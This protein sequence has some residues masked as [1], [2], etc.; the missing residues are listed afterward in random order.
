MSSLN[1]TEILGK[2]NEVRAVFV[3]GQRAVPFLEEMFAFLKEI[4]PLMD[5]INS[6]IQES[7]SRMPD[8]TSKLQSVT[9]ATE[10]ATTEILDLVDGSLAKMWDLK[11]HSNEYAEFIDAN[12][13]DDAKLIKLIR[14]ELT[15]KNDALL[16]EIEHIHKDKK[17]RRR[18]MSRKLELDKEAVSE[19]NYKLN[20]IMMALQVQD[21][22]AQQLAAAN[23]L[24]VSIRNRMSHL[25]Q[26]LGKDDFQSPAEALPSMPEVF[27]PNAKFDRSGDRQDLADDVIAA[28]ANGGTPEITTP[29]EPASQG[30]IDALFGGATTAASS[31]PVAPADI[32][33][34][35]GG[36]APAAPASQGDIDALF[37]GGTPAAPASPAD[38]D[39]LFSGDGA[40]AVQDRDATPPK[41][42]PASQDSIDQL[43]G[44]SGSGGATSQDDIDK[45]F[46]NG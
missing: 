7:T 30:D 46:S 27:D 41:A 42:E 45:L 21:I 34:L 25:I 38:I 3:L 23:H 1:I 11:D 26:R 36:G 39:A 19:V 5:E 4:S 20:N 13:W 29:A 15:G 33:A 32:D 17:A 31:D 16:A 37:G 35:F 22:T 9:Q 2:L 24:I 18:S 43:F 10:M 14:A 40:S 12:R 8:A 28:F 44:S 6:S